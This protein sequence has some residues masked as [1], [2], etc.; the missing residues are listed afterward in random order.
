[1]A[2]TFARVSAVLKLKR[3]DYSLQGKR[4]RLR[5]LEK[6]NKEKLVWLHHEAEQYL[7]AYLEAASIDEAGAALFQT[8]DKNHRLTGLP[9]LSSR[10]APYR[11]GTLRQSRTPGEHLQSHLPGHRHH[12]VPAERRRARSR[13]V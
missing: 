7:D 12:R 9:H 5:L 2:Y 8:L 1:M 10:Y 13:L 4:A 6:G 11:Q 3:G